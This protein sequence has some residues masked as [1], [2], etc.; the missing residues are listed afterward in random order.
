[1]RKLLAR[2]GAEVAFSCATPRPS[3][4]RSSPTTGVD[5]KSLKPLKG[6]LTR[7]DWAAFRPA[8]VKSLGKIDH[9]FHL[10]AI[11]DLAADPKEEMETNIEGIA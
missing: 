9:M 4:W 5:V 10:A 7:P 8:A 1:M 11:Y 6:D 3:A 2:P